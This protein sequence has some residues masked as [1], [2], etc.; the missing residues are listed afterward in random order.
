[1]KVELEWPIVPELERVDGGRTGFDWEQISYLIENCSIDRKFLDYI[2]DKSVVLVGPSPYMGK[3][4][5]GDWIDSFDVV[6]RMNKSWPVKE[7]HKPFIGTKTDIRWHNMN[8]YHRH[9]GPYNIEDMLE[10]GVEWLCSQ[11][12]L[13]LDYFHRDIK[14]FEKLN[15]GRI[16]FHCWT[17]IEQYMT[18]HHYLGTRMN[19]GPACVAELLSYDIKNI[20]V[21][22]LTFFREGWIDG[23]HNDEHEGKGNK[24]IQFG[25][26]AQ[27]PQIKLLKLLF[28]NDKRVSVDPEV[29]RVLN[30]KQGV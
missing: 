2:K 8:T 1:M 21:T 18:Y 15:E 16:N 13:R 26:H 25:N 23:Y 27:A 29:E 4:K 9:G 24:A 19:S 12:P 5:R 28:D 22:G 20:H 14:E 30:L 10:D 6:I 17:D 11:F 7:E 3:Q